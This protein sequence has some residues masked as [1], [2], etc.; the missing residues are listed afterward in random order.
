MSIHTPRAA[1]P[2][3]RRTATSLAAAA[4]CLAVTFGGGT[5]AA[6]SAFAAT[7]SQTD[8]VLGVGANETQRNLAWYSATD[9][10]QVAQFALASKVVDGAFPALA[11]SVSATG[12]ATTSGEFN[13]FAT[14]SELKENTEYVYRVGREGDW[15]ATYSFR[16]QDFEGDFNF[17]FFGDPQ[18]GS[19]G[20]VPS[21]SAGWV[22]TLN[23]ATAT[24]PDTELLFSAGDQVET[25][26]N[27]GQYEAFLQPDQLRE[28]P[29]VATNGN[30]DVGSKAYQQHFNTPNLDTTVGTGSV[31]ASGGDYWFIHKGVL[32]MDINSNS[33]DNAAHIAWMN[34]VVA[35]HGDEAKWK[36]LAFHHS[37]YSSGPHATDTDVI[38]RRNVL[39]TAISDL[40]IDLVLQGHDH[41]Y[42][43]SY[44][45]HNGEKANAAEE[46]GADSVVAGPGGVLYV[47]ANSASGSKYYSLQ[48]KN[49]WWLSAENQEKVRNYSAIDVS[50]EAI[51]IKTLRSQANG[52]DKPVNS[53]VDQVTL[54]REVEPDTD[55]Q[56]LQVTV[57][58]TAPGEFVWNIDGTNGLVDL[59]TAVDA[60]DH[61]SAVGS[62]NPIRVT[63]TRSSGPEWSISA[64]VGDFTSGEKSFSGR[65]LGWTPSVVQSGGDAVAG[66]RV[67]S[68]FL[69]GD[70]LSVSS[71]LG[72]AKGGHALGTAKLDAGLEL[73]IPV[74]V[75][76]GTYKATLTLTALS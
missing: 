41:S 47:T 32:F 25:A 1:K 3:H 53:I 40:G 75:T 10:A 73:D 64:Q 63:D 68:G 15:S 52:D 66:E 50:D 61:Y 17:L 24:Y 37:I 6:S 16:T 71:T 46:A 59:G 44:L 55:A 7:P 11:V 49:F 57:P 22:D 9:T 23:V 42:A 19:S 60:G 38:D 34:K 18:I 48:N 72:H 56:Q 31:T 62:I 45:I 35:E 39:P 13:R 21:D 20:N 69:G 58:E 8:I 5:L 43:R 65:Y 54:T 33:R 36:V 12:G 30:H 26:S 70:G 29:F 14:L 51:T 76:D 67:A 74:D 2:V 28:I 4:V 27:E